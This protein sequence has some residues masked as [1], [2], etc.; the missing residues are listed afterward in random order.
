MGICLGMQLLMT[1]SEEFGTHKGLNLVSGKVV[2]LEERTERIKIPHV[3]WNSLL[4]PSHVQNSNGNKIFPEN[5]IL[6]NTKPGMF[7]YFVHSYMVVPENPVH[8]LAETKYGNNIF[9][10]ALRKDNLFACQFH[11]ER[12]GEVGLEIY[13]QFLKI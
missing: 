5:S 1:E 9:C 2:R 3:G 7:V 6:E 13:K 11:P 4:L 12:S 8:I 10:S